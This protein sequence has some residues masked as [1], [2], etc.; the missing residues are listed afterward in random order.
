MVEVAL[1]AP[2]LAIT[3]LGAA[4]MARAF[5]AQLAVQNGARAGA[6]AGALLAAPTGS[7]VA[8]R[9]QTELNNTPGVNASG[10][11]TQAGTA[12]TCGTATITVT[13]TQSNGTSACTGAASTAVAG[14]SSTATPC[15]ANV[16]VQYTFT[17]LTPWPGLPHSFAF[18]RS[19]MYRRYQCPATGCS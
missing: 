10:S 9:A 12:F 16:R 13:F 4:D 15:Y 6:E 5:S 8:T 7:T 1:A 19:T 17:T 14:T 3:L 2:V 11:C 18:D